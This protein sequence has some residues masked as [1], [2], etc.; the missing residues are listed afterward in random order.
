MIIVCGPQNNYV[1]VLDLLDEPVR[2]FKM[3][4]WLI[5][6]AVTS[7]LN[8]MDLVSFKRTVASSNSAFRGSCRHLYMFIYLFI[9]TMFTLTVVAVAAD[10]RVHV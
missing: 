8:T 2:L 10:L 3:Y 4:L 9:F 7:T 1:D 6:L 5:H